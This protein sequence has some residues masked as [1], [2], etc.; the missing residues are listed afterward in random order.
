MSKGMKN[1]HWK[2]SKL[3]EDMFRALLQFSEINSRTVNCYL[4]VTRYRI[5]WYFEEQR[6]LNGVIALEKCRFGARR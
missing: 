2:S 3:S 5:I 1:R 6:P 4:R